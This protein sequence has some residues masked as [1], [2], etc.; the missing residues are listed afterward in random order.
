M[1][2]IDFGEYLSEQ[3]QKDIA[4]EVLRERLT[5]YLKGGS[6]VDRIIG[7]VAYH[8]VWA[9]LAEVDIDVD[10]LAEKTATVVRNLSA[11][12]VFHPASYGQP[13][14]TAY[15]LLEKA[16]YENKDMITKRVKRLINQTGAEQIRDG[17]IDAVREAFAQPEVTP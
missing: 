16:V 6:D 12:T 13:A 4:T 1:T 7:N 11:Y 10:V 8:V 3:E 15:T 5:E 17:I 9:A 2:G 14:S